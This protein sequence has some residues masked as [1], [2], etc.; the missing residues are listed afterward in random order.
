MRHL[1]TFTRWCACLGIC[2]L[3]LCA[4]LNV[5]DIATRRVI[6]LNIVGMVDVT[7]LMIMAC[8][9]L[10]IPYTFMKEAHIDV[11]FVTN[12][13]PLRLRHAMMSAW[14]LIGA[15]FMG[16]VTWY[17]GIAAVQALHNGDAST[18]I[19]IPIIFYWLPLL[20]GCALSVLV[21]LAMCVSYAGR[22]SRPLGEN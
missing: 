3:L 19:G 16:L 10:C 21:C 14:G 22:A 2:L 13:L 12:M 9:F 6:R 20:F 7:Q 4:A 11:D 18:T 5:G 15:S 8:A 17:A 1:E